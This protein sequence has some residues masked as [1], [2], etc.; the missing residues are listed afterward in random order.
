VPTHKQILSGCRIGRRSIY[1]IGNFDVGVT[2][3]SQQTRALNLACAMIEEGLIS[4]SIPGRQP[5]QK[6]SIAIVGGGFAGLTFAA[7]LIA[8][9]ANVE[10]SLF[11]ERDVLLPL[12][13]GSDARWL[14]PNIYTWPEAGS[15]M[16]AAMLP[17]MNWTA[18]RASDVTVQLLAEWKIFASRPDAKIELFCN[19]RHLQIQAVARRR[20]L[21]LEWVGENRDPKD[22]GILNDAQKSAIGASKE[23]DHIVLAIGFGLERGGTT[24]YWRNEQLGQ[25]SLKEPRKTYLV[26]G[27]GDGGMIDLLR[28]RI[29]YFRQDRILDQLFSGRRTLMTAMERLATRQRWT[30]PPA[31]FN[32]FETLFESSGLTGQ[33]FRQA[34]DDLRA[35]L[36]RDTEVIFRIKHPNFSALFSRGS[37]QNRLL[38]YLLFKC[39]GFFPT[40]RKMQQIIDQYS[41]SEDCIVTRHG[42]FVAKQF[43][44]VLVG[45]LGQEF[46][47]REKSRRPLTLTNTPKWLGGYFGFAG[48][49][50]QVK[51]LSNDQKKTWRKEY[52]P[53]PTNLL[54]S[55]LCSGIAG[56]LINDH[57][58]G[59]RLRVTL[60]RAITIHGQELLQQACDYQGAQVGNNQGAGR[61]FP[62]DT[63]T[64]GVAY[65]CRKIVRSR[66]KITNVSLR[67]TMRRLRLNNASSE[68]SRDVGFVLAIPL[69]ESGERYTWPSPVVGV[70]YVDSDAP[71]YYI[72]D[73][74]LAVLV[75]IAQR[76]LESLASP[77]VEQLG[78]VRNFPLS[79]IAK[80][81]RAAAGLPLVAS[82]TLELAGITPPSTRVPFQLNY[83]FSEFLP[84][85][86]FQDN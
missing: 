64:I 76:F 15:E 1:S 34:C 4:C 37:F 59:H 26:S 33:E 21:L 47:R 20:K 3:L 36:R 23:F 53:S 29:S 16:T 61:T 79:E 77:T 81:R 25:P 45:E 60:H 71:H 30:R 18:S 80:R 32:E 66:R 9:N 19:T 70:I 86:S 67:E 13:H 22:G 83:D 63:A 35:R 49:S 75:S 44:R 74:R 48:S 5:P 12:Q 84:T 68:M 72:D 10:I 50:R 54:A 24:S 2:V 52:L 7:G 6:R 51:L 73:D 41:I 85:R 17:I 28:L 65:R 69:L 8:K 43:H 46:A 58:V 62:V 57:P 42:T 55:A 56:L 82:K 38:V 14:H 40:N 11:E 78:H 39:G 27:G 31:L